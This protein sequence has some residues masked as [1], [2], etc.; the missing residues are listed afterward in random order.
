MSRREETHGRYRIVAGLLGGKPTAR[1]FL[2]GAPQGTGIMAEATGPDL[3]AAIEAVRV[4]LDARE[5]E[6][7]AARRMTAHGFSVPTTQEYADALAAIGPSDGQRAMLAAHAEAGDTGL[8]AT[9]L[10]KAAGYKNFNAANL[11]YGL[12]GQKVVDHL[13]LTLPDSEVREGES[14]MTVALA[15]WVDTPGEE[16][17]WI[18]HPELRA[19]L[20]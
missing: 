20:E 3:D 2:D 1:A 16:F 9:Q 19:A 8:T 11:Q 18:M 5:A 12:L 15:D 7:H 14:A 10:A 4:D 6:A 17:V 13:H